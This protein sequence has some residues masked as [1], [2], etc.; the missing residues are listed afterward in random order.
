MITEGKKRAIEKYLTKTKHKVKKYYLEFFNVNVIDKTVSVDLNVIPTENNTSYLYK[1]F[2]C[3][4]ADVVG[5]VSNLIS[6]DE[7]VIF[8]IENTYFN[9]KPVEPDDFSFSDDFISTV[10][11]KI[12]RLMG[13]FK[14]V[15]SIN[16]KRMDFRME[17]EYKISKVEFTDYDYATFFITGKV[18]K[19]FFDEVEQ[20]DL[21]NGIKDLIA[22]YLPYFQ[23]DD[24][25]RIEDYLH[26][27][28]SNDQNINNCD[29]YFTVY[30]DYDN[31]LGHEPELTSPH[32]SDI[33]F[34]AIED[35]INGD[36]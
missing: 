15:K 13:V 6:L 30:L 17:I 29:V 18:N 11:N 7:K 8:E 10:E 32:N 28:L 9:G 34:S 21:P 16:Y 22:S 25:I 19:V 14:T 4:A 26:D 20:T 5:E 33:F 36:Y 12:K 31:V 27:L 2:I 35:F 24:R 3:S 1:G 23:E